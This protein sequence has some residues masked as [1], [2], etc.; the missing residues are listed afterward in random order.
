MPEKFNGL[1]KTDSPRGKEALGMLDG[2]TEGQAVGSSTMIPG[3]RPHDP[4][5]WILKKVDT[6]A[7]DLKTWIVDG[8]YCGIPFYRLTIKRMEDR[9]GMTV[10]ELP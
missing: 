7:A 10:E 5:V 6:V 9:I 8:S 2:L 4:V 1:Y 3:L